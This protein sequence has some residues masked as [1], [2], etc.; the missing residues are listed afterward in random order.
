[1]REKIDE[2]QKG[3]AKQLAFIKKFCQDLED[4]IVIQNRNRIALLRR[5]EPEEV[6]SHLDQIRDLKNTLTQV[7]YFKSYTNLIR[8]DEILRQQIKIATTKPVPS[9]E[10]VKE[11]QGKATFWFKNFWQEKERTGD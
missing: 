7:L 2:I 9:V 10:D 4:T 11:N 5:R 6:Q 3:E 1:M 8:D